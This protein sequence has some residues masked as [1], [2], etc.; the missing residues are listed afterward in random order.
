M[1]A[2]LRMFLLAPVVYSVI[3]V[4]TGYIVD[5]SFEPIVDELGEPIVY[6]E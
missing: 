2:A 1:N 3:P 5:T 6:A 4:D